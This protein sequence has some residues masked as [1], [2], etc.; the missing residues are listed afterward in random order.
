MN[1]N[2]DSASVWAPVTSDAFQT[3]KE[4]LSQQQVAALKTRLSHSLCIRTNDFTHLLRI[5]FVIQF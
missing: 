5:F 2:I 1:T 4:S 3:V